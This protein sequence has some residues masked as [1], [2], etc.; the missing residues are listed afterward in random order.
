M[1]NN[2]IKRNVNGNEYY[3]YDLPRQGGKRRRL[4]G[5]TE[6]EVKAKLEA[7]EPTEIPK[8]LPI[9]ILYAYFMALNENG[10]KENRIYKVAKD[11]IPDFFLEINSAEC[12]QKDVDRVLSQCEGL[13]DYEKIRLSINDFIRWGTENGCFDIDTVPDKR[14]YL[15]KV[16][17]EHLL[18]LRKTVLS[19][20]ED[21]S[22]LLSA[23]IPSYR[24]ASVV[25][26]V[27]EAGMRLPAIMNCVGMTE[28]NGKI[29]LLT[30]D[31]RYLIPKSLH[32]MAYTLRELQVRENCP[33]LFGSLN[34]VTISKN[35]SDYG[36]RIGLM[37][38]SPLSVRK[39]FGWYLLNEKGF[40]VYQLSEI[41][42]DDVNTVL[43]TY[44]DY[45]DKSLDG[46][47]DGI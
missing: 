13:E 30:S 28:E 8:K 16:S 6:E 35:F 5:K 7:V 25:L 33:K 40:N 1:A 37:G 29:Y 17:S 42:H 38:I 32:G 14:I 45:Y 24:Y 22:V 19:D 26:T 34:R 36:K 20:L 21:M 23:Y 15:D 10:V 18:K 4:Y 39:A 43:R 9:K 44:S 46:Y 41:L 2:I 3:T 12:S 47:A 11:R 31:E 27:A